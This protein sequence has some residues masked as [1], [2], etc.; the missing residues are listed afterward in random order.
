M[1]HRYWDGSVWRDVGTMPELVSGLRGVWRAPNEVD[2]RRGL[3]H[4]SHFW[5][6][7]WFVSMF[8]PVEPEYL[9]CFERHRERWSLV[10]VWDNGGFHGMRWYGGS[11]RFSGW[12]T[13]SGQ[14]VRWPDTKNVYLSDLPPSSPLV[15]LVYGGGLR[16]CSY[17]GGP[18]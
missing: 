16:W 18:A 15:Q 9:H 6:W 3:V 11:P 12:V 17:G 13:T 2:L 8:Q 1:S 5:D 7:G 10:S 14:P 4:S